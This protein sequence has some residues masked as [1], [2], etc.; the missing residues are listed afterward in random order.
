MEENTSI[1]ALD[2]SRT[3]VGRVVVAE[4][5]AEFIFKSLVPNTGNTS[6]HTLL[7]NESGFG[8]QGGKR[9]FEALSSGLYPKLTS[10]RLDSNE[11]TGTACGAP[12]QVPAACSAT[13]NLCMDLCV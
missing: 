4:G 11:L 9:L 2:I 1:Q 13:T 10:L 7:L 12:M 5:N 6:L 3:G 8:E